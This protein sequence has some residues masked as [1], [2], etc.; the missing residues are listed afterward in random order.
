MQPTPKSAHRDAAL[1]N[2][3]VA[4]RNSMYIGDRV[5]R[6]VPVKK[7]SDYFYDYKKGAWFRNDAS[8]R[9]PGGRA[10]R[11]GY[12]ISDTQYVCNE[13]AMAHPVPVELINNADDALQPW[14][15]GVEFA[16][17]KIMLAKEVLVSTM[18]MTSGNW[19]TSEDVE[20]GWASTAGT[21]TFITDVLAAKE[22][23]RKLI[24]RYPNVMT[25]DALTYKELKMC[26]DVLDRI[27]YT[28]T[29]GK[30]ADVTPNV[31]A[32]LLDL[33]EILIGGAIYS[34]AEEVVA[35]TDFNAVDLWMVN[36]TKGSAFLA[37]RP[38]NPGLMQ[39][40]AGYIFEWDGGAGQES[41]KLAGDVFRDVRYW[42][43]DAEKQWV[44]EASENF[45]EKV[46]SADAGYL[47]YDTIST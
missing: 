44:I 22:T 26:D 33:E 24:G 1:S 40:A 27:K 12:V 47:F 14:V 23:V 20:G 41:R 13:T 17:D 32:Q 28:G 29:Q 16:T 42:W 31:L 2:I 43:E 38:P 10:R 9:G 8:Y 36:A 19:T 45:D 37:Y 30:P 7:Q 25:L 34:D 35:G 15:T 4:Y 21:N 46:T 6:H 3:S 5:F 18:C 39:P 11:G